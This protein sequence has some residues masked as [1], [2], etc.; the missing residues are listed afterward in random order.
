[1][2]GNLAPVFKSS[3]TARVFS[4]PVAKSAPNARGFLAHDAGSA[5]NQAPVLP[6]D[7]SV[8]DESASASI[9]SRTARASTN[10]ATFTAF[11]SAVDV[12]F[13]ASVAGNT[14]AK[15]LAK[16]E[17]TKKAVCKAKENALK[18]AAEAVAAADTLEI[19]TRAVNIASF[20]SAD[21]NTMTATQ[22]A[23]ASN[24]AEQA[25]IDAFNAMERYNYECTEA[26]Q[27]KRLFEEALDH[28]DIYAST[29]AVAARD[30][31]N[32]VHRALDDD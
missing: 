9:A 10:V 21:G 3:P 19:M 18:T 5:A 11:R 20:I 12:S 31:K 1:M 15:T 22:I 29:A 17:S 28:L 6:T 8:A 24:V 14:F 2:S 16:V 4:V 27:A 26:A 25:V 30:M 32:A 7:E 13:R 23:N